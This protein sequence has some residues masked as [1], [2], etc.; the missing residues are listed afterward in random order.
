M[1]NV[2]NKIQHFDFSLKYFIPEMQ[3][4]IF[5]FNLAEALERNLKIIQVRKSN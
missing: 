3:V 5:K 1:M 2:K 4:N